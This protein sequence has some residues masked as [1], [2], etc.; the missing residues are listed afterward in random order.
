[1]ETPFFC[2]RYIQRQKSFVSSS[3]TFF[4]PNENYSDKGIAFFDNP[5]R[6]GLV[7]TR[8]EWKYAGE[9]ETLTL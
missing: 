2:E 8:Q 1:M 5:V 9:I 3:I 6:A 7:S 4:A